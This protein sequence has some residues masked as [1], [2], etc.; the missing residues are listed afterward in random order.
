[1]IF[2]IKNGDIIRFKNDNTRDWVA[3][4]HTMCKNSNLLQSYNKNIKDNT[5]FYLFGGLWYEGNPLTSNPYGKT[6]G[7]LK[8]GMFNNIVAIVGNISNKDD[9]YKYL[10]FEK[11]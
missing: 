6:L 7:H 11:I 3:I 8:R 4:H 2:E 5:G 10:K 9:Y 1:M